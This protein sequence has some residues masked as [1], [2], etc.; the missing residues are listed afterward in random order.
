VDGEGRSAVKL[1]CDYCR[2][3]GTDDDRSRPCP[4]CGGSGVVDD[5]SCPC[6]ATVLTTD[7]EPC[8]FCG[9]YTAAQ[10]LAREESV[11]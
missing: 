7:P 2:G 8:L 3:L 4:E 11:Q 5:G 1:L 9:G 10:L 6:G